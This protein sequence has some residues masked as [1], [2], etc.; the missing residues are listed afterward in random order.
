MC[1][2]SEKKAFTVGDTDIPV[3]MDDGQGRW[4]NGAYTLTAA[5]TLTRTAI[6]SSSNGGQATVFQA[7]AKDVFCTLTSESLI[8]N[9]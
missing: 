8:P 3:S 7:G 2:R 5:N 4:E 6:H 9:R 1:V